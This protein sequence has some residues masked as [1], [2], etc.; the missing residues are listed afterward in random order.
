MRTLTPPLTDDVTTSLRVGDEVTLDGTIFILRDAT[1]QRIFEEQIPPP[2]SLVGAVVIHGAPSFEKHGD[3]YT[4]LSMGPTTSMRVE[5]YTPSLIE[6]YGVRAV[7]GKGGM[8]PGT[9]AAMKQFHA[10]YLALVG[11][12][13]ALVTSQIEEVEELWW[14]D[15]YGEALWKIRVKGLGPALVA[16]DCQGNNLFQSVQGTALGRIDAI[17]SGR[18]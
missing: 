1:H 6:K 12:S 7:V 13:S 15:L 2:P 8:G 5:K 16:I 18:T 11:G 17:L 10:V 3:R 14:P 9:T 4:I